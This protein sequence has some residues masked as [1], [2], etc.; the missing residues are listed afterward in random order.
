MKLLLIYICKA[1]IKLVLY[2]FKLFSALFILSFLVACTSYSTN[3]SVIEQH[4]KQQH[5][6]LALQALEKQ[7]DSKLNKLLYLLNKASLQRMNQ[8]FQASNASFEQAK[9]LI[10]KLYGISVRDQVGSFALNDTTK[11]YRGDDHEQVLI[12]L[13]SAL[14]YLAL[15][16]LDD[17]RVEALQVDLKLTDLASRKPAN[18]PSVYVEDAFSRY[19][20]GM[21]YEELKEWSDALIAYRKS[22]EAYKKYAETFNTSI[23]TFLKRDLLRLLDKQ[24]IK[25]E[26]EHYK[27]TFKLNGWLSAKELSNYGEL[28]FLLHNGLSPIKRESTITTASPSLKRL[29]SI[30]L[31]T[32]E[33]R[34]AGSKSARISIA[35]QES[36]TQL[37]ENIE[38]IAIK[39]LESQM[40]AITARA[41]A[42][43]VLKYQMAKKVEQEQGGLLSVIVNVANMVTERADTRSWLTLPENIQLAR[44]AVK[45]GIYDVK[46]E[47][48][49]ASN[50]VMDSFLVKD[51]SIK[52]GKKTYLEKYWLNPQS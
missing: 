10:D 51:I 9:R 17:A 37:V 38:A 34:M 15:S 39:S 40:P 23:P 43:A 50:R 6:E 35:E 46:I 22:Y 5:P 13:Y 14:N 31:P 8:N 24:G 29:I 27:A 41:L 20:T 32:Y 7:P 3:F 49:N 21:I 25:D 44:I 26:F 1:Q 36:K 11:V 33:R 19:V 18:N 12:H 28:I 45:P 47:I 52:R 16:Q 42:R 30:A 4:I 2:T 48:L